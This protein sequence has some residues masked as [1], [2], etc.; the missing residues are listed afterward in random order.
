MYQYEL[1]FF[2]LK[3]MKCLPNMK[4]FQSLKKKT[5][6]KLR[7]LQISVVP[8]TYIYTYFKYIYSLVG[9]Y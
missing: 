6:D 5:L 2:A 7:L 8:Y 9:T 4:S 3:I 1:Y